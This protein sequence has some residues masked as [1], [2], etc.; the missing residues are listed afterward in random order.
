LFTCR[1]GI[2]S[3]TKAGRCK[4]GEKG[5]GEEKIKKEEKGKEGKCNW[6]RSKKRERL[7][8]RQDK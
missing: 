7:N 5:N 2:T 3:K 1:A 4:F 6:M 8:S